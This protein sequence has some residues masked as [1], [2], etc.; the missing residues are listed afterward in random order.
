[1]FHFVQLNIYFYFLVSLL[2][3]PFGR[4]SLLADQPWDEDIHKLFGVLPDNNHL[5][6]MTLDSKSA[7]SDK[8]SIGSS[9]YL[10]TH[11][12]S[13]SMDW[14]EEEVDASPFIPCNSKQKHFRPLKV[15]YLLCLLNLEVTTHLVAVGS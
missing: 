2:V 3:F 4:S 5:T 13:P 8:H 11:A 1:M 7:S 9:K 6:D 15:S 14:E 10:Q 12:F